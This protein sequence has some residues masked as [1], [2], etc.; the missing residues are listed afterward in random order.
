MGWL[1]LAALAQNATRAVFA[2]TITYQKAGPGA[3]VVTVGEFDEAALEASLIDGGLVQSAGPRISV[4]L[5]DLPGGVAE[6]GD[7]VSVRSG[8]Y[9]VMEVEPDG[10]GMARL[11]LV[12]G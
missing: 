8:S 6:K 7:L 12:G 2:E 1:D 4:R 5:A 3:L 11:I 10:H 9:E